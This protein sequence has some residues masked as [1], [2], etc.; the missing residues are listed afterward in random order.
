MNKKK[1]NVLAISLVIIH[2][3]IFVAGVVLGVLGIKLDDIPCLI[4]SIG[5][6]M[7]GA[8][9]GRIYDLLGL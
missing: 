5:T 8:I 9:F 6:F 2:V 4:A 1:K 7:T 3:S